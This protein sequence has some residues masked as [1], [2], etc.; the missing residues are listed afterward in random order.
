MLL[1]IKAKSLVRG[2]EL[3]LHPPAFAAPI[4]RSLLGM[5]NPYYKNNDDLK[6]IFIHIPRT[7]GISFYHAVFDETSGHRGHI[8]AIRFKMYNLRKF[9]EYSKVAIVRNPW[10]RLYSA[11]SYLKG[12]IEASN[13][14][15]GRW[16]RKYL[17]NKDFSDFVYGLKNERYRKQILQYVHFIPQY[18]WITLPNNC[19]KPVCNTLIRFELL[20]K[21]MKKVEK[22]LGV[23]IEMSHVNSSNKGSYLKA[24]DH[25]MKKIVG[26]IYRKDVEM[27]D[28][29]FAPK[30]KF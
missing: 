20:N 2:L 10:D 30:A 13:R 19:N 28:Y 24:Y 4:F 29:E 6:C 7:G 8:P 21:E 9:N 12:R 3:N 11:F 25:Q 16:A 23:E 26:N 18:R 14:D 22:A 1:K 5:Y 27:F 17:R 15:D